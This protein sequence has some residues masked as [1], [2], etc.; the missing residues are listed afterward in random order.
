MSAIRAKT[1]QSHVIFFIEL[2][3]ILAYF[4]RLRALLIAFPFVY[5]SNDFSYNR[6]IHIPYVIWQILGLDLNFIIS[7]FF[8]LP[9]KSV[10]YCL[11]FFQRVI[12]SRNCLVVGKWR[13]PDRKKFSISIF[14]AE[15]IYERCIVH[16]LD[17]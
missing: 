9:C 11:F 16:V 17:D 13:K 1:W 15:G 12:F 4:K 10:F 5:A 7:F 6:F 3:F 2:Q 8:S 14:S